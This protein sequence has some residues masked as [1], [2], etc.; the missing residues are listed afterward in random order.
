MASDTKFIPSPFLSVSLVHSF[1]LP[2]DEPAIRYIVTLQNKSIFR[3][4]AFYSLFTHPWRRKGRG[5]EREG[6]I[7]KVVGTKLRQS[8]PEKFG[9]LVR[10]GHVMGTA[11]SLPSP[12]PHD[13]LATTPFDSSTCRSI[14][15]VRASPSVKYA[16]SA[17]VGR[18]R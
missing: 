2:L 15:F 1:S 4:E 16:F 9:S 6:P 13:G 12:V 10:L 3:A 8:G 11:A 7:L 5:R 18:N 14:I 17:L